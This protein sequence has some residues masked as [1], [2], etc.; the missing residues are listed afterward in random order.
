MAHLE[1]GQVIA[2]ASG[3][4]LFRCQDSTIAAVH[5][6]DNETESGEDGERNLVGEPQ[7]S[8]LE[9]TPAH[10]PLTSMSDDLVVA[11][12]LDARVVAAIGAGYTTG[13]GFELMA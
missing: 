4:D 13:V 10:L 11:R 5:D 7:T 6:D 3:C 8:T 2:E 1:R 9:S 12:G